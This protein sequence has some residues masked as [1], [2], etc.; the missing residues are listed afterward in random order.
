MKPRRFLSLVRLSV[1]EQKLHSAESKMLL[2]LLTHL[3]F[4]ISHHPQLSVFFLSLLQRQ[5]DLSWLRFKGWEHSRHWR[6]GWQH[7]PDRGGGCG[8]GEGPE[9]KCLFSEVTHRSSSSCLFVPLVARIKM[10]TRNE[11]LTSPTLPTPDPLPP[12]LGASDLLSDT[13][14]QD[15]P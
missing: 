8:R 6:K 11:T 10:V 5:T 1:F 14:N 9:G 4:T 7:P 13:T 12:P 2:L 3:P 15:K